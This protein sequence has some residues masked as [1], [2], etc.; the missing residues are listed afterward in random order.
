VIFLAPHRT[1]RLTHIYLSWVVS[2]VLHPFFFSFPPGAASVQITTTPCTSFENYLN[3]SRRLI[4][5][6]WY[7]VL[8]W[9]GAQHLY[10]SVDQ[11]DNTRS[12][13]CFSPHKH[14]VWNPCGHSFTFERVLVAPSDHRQ[15]D[16]T[17]SIWPS[18]GRQHKYVNGKVCNNINSQLDAT[19]ITLL[20]ISV[21]TTCFG[22]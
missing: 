13:S 3:L 22:R 11:V 14:N 17:R 10:R 2:L 6:S 1:S 20:I 9:N 4:I 15:V 21:S 5:C 8:E 19:I 12:F 7:N 18:A 16:N